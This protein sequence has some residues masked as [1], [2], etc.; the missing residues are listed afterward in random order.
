MIRVSVALLILSILSPDLV[1]IN[2]ADTDLLE[3]LPG[4][5]PAKA[6]AIVEFRET[7]GPFLTIGDLDLV[8]GI[9][10]AT[11]ASLADLV[12]AGTPAVDLADT[13]HWL[14]ETAPA[15]TLLTLSFLDVGQG[16][17]S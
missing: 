17:L 5:G 7:F 9:G 16:T 3:T 13:L 11:V 12:T 1:N 14:P 8:A 6:E 4:I 15:E 2:T 10:P